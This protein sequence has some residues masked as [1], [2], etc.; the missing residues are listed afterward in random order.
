MPIDKHKGKDDVCYTGSKLLRANIWEPQFDQ[1]TFFG[2][3]RHYFKLCNPMNFFSAERRLEHARKIMERYRKG[4]PMDDVSMYQLW[5][6]KYLYDSTFDRY[7]DDKMFLPGRPAAFVPMTALIGGGMLTYYQS[8]API[9]FWQWAFQ[10]LQLAIHYTARSPNSKVTDKQLVIGYGA[11]TLAA[12]STALLYHT[13]FK[14]FAPI[15]SRMGPA[16]A[17]V[18][19]TCVTVPFTRYNDIEDGIV[20]YDNKDKKLAYSTV[21]AKYSVLLD[22]LKHALVVAPPLVAAPFYMEYLE[23]RG[24][25]CRYPY[26]TLPNQMLFLALF[27]TFLTPLF[28]AIVSDRASM[29]FD[30]LQPELQNCITKRGADPPPRRVFFDLGL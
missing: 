18:V 23:E 14:C 1:N 25:L 29:P 24:T 28:R 4:D 5:K 2:R 17:A 26:L 8:A 12:V 19:G 22:T 11:G 3:S 9:I 21:A 7:T 6:A 30:R 13:A 15:T 20:I 27:C 10:T 16:L